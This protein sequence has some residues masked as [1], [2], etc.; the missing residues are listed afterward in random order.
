LQ[1][2]SHTTSRRRF[3][4]RAVAFCYSTTTR[5]YAGA[6]RDVCRWHG[7]LLTATQD[8]GPMRLVWHVTDWCC[9][10]RPATGCTEVVDQRRR[11]R[12]GDG[13][14]TRLTSLEGVCRLAISLAELGC[15][16]LPTDRGCSQAD[17]SRAR[18]VVF[19]SVRGSRPAGAATCV[20]GRRGWTAKQ[21][22][23]AYIPRILRPVGGLITSVSTSRKAGGR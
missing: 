1:E 13:N 5:A 10:L 11:N 17:A 3:P 8:G 7:D 20:V 22:H 19:K 16:L 15:S 2:P 21:D 12:A 23:P 6:I 14:R 4:L 18:L 9:L